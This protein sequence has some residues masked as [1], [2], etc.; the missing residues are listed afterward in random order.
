MSISMAPAIS[1]EI[2]LSSNCGVDIPTKGKKH[3]NDTLSYA[4]KS[5]IKDSD[6]DLYSYHV[7]H[8]HWIPGTGKGGD[9]RFGLWSDVQNKITWDLL[10]DSMGH[11][12]AY[13]Y[14][15]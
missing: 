10:Y 14:M 3:G 15:C 1:F 4:I 5:Q 12:S 8:R 6:K 13:M 11:T 7:K 2:L 9:D